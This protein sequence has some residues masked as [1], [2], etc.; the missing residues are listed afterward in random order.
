MSTLE[1]DPAVAQRQHTSRALRI[2]LRRVLPDY[3]GEL[4]CA[5]LTALEVLADSVADGGN[6][7]HGSHEHDRYVATSAAI[8]VRQ[9]DERLIAF[10]TEQLEGVAD[11]HPDDPVIA[12][13]VEAL[14]STPPAGKQ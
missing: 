14:A 3:L 13:L 7:S 4:V 1:P 9:Y 5:L 6:Y 8:A 10:V 11:D 12:Q 2:A